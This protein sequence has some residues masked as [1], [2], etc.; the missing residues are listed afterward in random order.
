MDELNFISV[1]D[2]IG[3]INNGVGVILSMRVIDKIYQLGYWFDK[4]NN[5][6]LSCDNNFLEDLKIKDIYE[7]K[8]YKTLAYYIHNIVLDNKDEI[9][10]VFRENYL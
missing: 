1:V 7:Y 2:Y 10:K 5:Y 3:E 8:E 6:I 4:E 9:L